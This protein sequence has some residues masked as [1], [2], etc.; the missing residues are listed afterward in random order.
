MTGYD[1]L[2]DLAA[3]RASHRRYLPDPV[4]REDIEKMAAMARLAPSG[5]NLQPWRLLALT[6]RDFIGKLAGAS[7]AEYDALVRRLPEEARERPEKFGFYVSHFRDAPLVFVVLSRRSEIESD[8][9]ARAHGVAAPKPECFDLD[10]LG[11]GAFIQN[12][13]LAA[14]SLGYGACWVAAPVMYAQARVEELL[15]VEPPWHA[16][17]IVSVTRP[18]RE[19][20]GA[21]KKE[22][23]EILTIVP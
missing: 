5:H 1:E 19:R 18:V 13:L 21:P 14:E 7:A 9:L 2:L 6:G 8:T 20:R 22:V 15:G 4:P 10:C 17:S 11:V 23:S 12:L 3:R 16:V